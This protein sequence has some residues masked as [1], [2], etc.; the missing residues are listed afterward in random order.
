MK[1]VIALVVFIATA[2]GASAQEPAVPIGNWQS[3]ASETITWAL[4]PAL[5]GGE[6]YL[7]ID[8]S[9]DGG[10]GGEWGE[11]FCSGGSPYFS[12]RLSGKSERV[13]GRFGPSG[14]GVIDLGRLGRSTFNWS[15][16]AVNDLVIVLPKNWQG[17]KEILYRAR[18]TRDGKPAPPTPPPGAAGPLSSAVA[19]YREFNKDEKAALNRYAGKTLVLEGRRGDLIQLSDGGAAVHIADGFTSRALVLAFRDQKEVSG[20]GEGTQFRFRCT[21]ESFDYLYVHMKDCSIVR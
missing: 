1:K 18:M 7:K 4:H 5:T 3:A 19:L 11:Y 12:C 21:V 14:D 10:F 20:I 2:V 13:S 16:S 6:L 15:T 9:K 17:A 8:I